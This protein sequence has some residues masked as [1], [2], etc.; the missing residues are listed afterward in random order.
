MIVLIALIIDVGIEQRQKI[1]CVAATIQDQ[2]H[3]KM[4]FQTACSIGAS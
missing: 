3:Q 2:H 1:L 4:I